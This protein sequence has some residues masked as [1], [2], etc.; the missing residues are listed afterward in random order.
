MLPL[1][2]SLSGLLLG[3]LTRALTFV[4]RSLDQTAQY[5]ESTYAF[6][7]AS[8]ATSPYVNSAYDRRHV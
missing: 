7:A 8:A 6:T 5:R 4:P 3:L 1:A 2:S